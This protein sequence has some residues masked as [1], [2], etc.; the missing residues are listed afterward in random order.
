MGPVGLDE[1]GKLRQD[2]DRAVV[3]PAVRDRANFEAGNPASP[4]RHDPM[5]AVGVTPGTGRK[6]NIMW[7][8]RFVWTGPDSKRLSVLL[9]SSARGEDLCVLRPDRLFRATSTF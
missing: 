3:W 5:P 4:F 1:L 7:H 9:R 2:E 8:V 6:L